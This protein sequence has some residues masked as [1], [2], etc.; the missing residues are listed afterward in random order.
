M[1]Q[2]L[3]IIYNKT[4]TRLL[5]CKRIEIGSLS[6]IPQGNQYLTHCLYDVKDTGCVQVLSN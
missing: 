4:L 1:N 6:R 3:F 2:E 5:H